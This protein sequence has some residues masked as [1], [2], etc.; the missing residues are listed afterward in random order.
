MYRFCL[1]PSIIRLALEIAILTAVE[2]LGKLKSLLP[3]E[4]LLTL[5]TYVNRI[6]L[7][8]A[9]PS[10]NQDPYSRQ[11]ITPACETSMKHTFFCVCAHIRPTLV[12]YS[13]WR[14]AFIGPVCLQI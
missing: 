9:S 12:V 5:M 2:L 10:S 11:L 4:H 1:S 6:V 14:K 3:T 13:N 8:G 7:M